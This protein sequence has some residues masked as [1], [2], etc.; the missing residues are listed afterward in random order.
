VRVCVIDSDARSGRQTNGSRRPVSRRFRKGSVRVGPA[1]RGWRLGCLR[2][3]ERSSM[4][5][6]LSY[7]PGTTGGAWFSTSWRLGRL[8]TRSTRVGPREGGC[9]GY[10]AHPR[11]LL[12]WLSHV[13]GT[14]ALTNAHRP[15]LALSRSPPRILKPPRKPTASVVEHTPVGEGNCRNDGPRQATRQRSPAYSI[16]VAWGPLRGGSFGGH[17]DAVSADTRRLYRG[18][19]GTSR[20]GRLCQTSAP[21]GDGATVTEPRIARRQPCGVSM[22]SA[23]AGDTSRSTNLKRASSAYHCV[24][25]TPHRLL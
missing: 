3:S 21:S 22:W 18:A 8:S 10:V 5:N 14:G 6:A 1:F 23:G 16:M 25:F 24:K 13:A 2:P 12:R 7:R 20:L 9:A 19:H 15:A 17:H 4:S 11:C